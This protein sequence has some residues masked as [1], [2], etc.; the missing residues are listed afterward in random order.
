MVTSPELVG[1]L[2]A[3]EKRRSLTINAQY[4]F[5]IFVRESFQ[6]PWNSS[7]FENK[8]RSESLRS[9]SQYFSFLVYINFRRLSKLWRVLTDTSPYIVPTIIIADRF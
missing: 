1:V 2:S 4:M 9:S 8:C 6:K 5:Y 3:V 7:L